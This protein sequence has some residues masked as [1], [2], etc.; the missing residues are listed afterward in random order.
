MKRILSVNLGY[1]VLTLVCVLALIPS[2]SSKRLA[3]NTSTTQHVTQ[4]REFRGVWMPTIY[5]NEY[6][7]LSRQEAREL[8]SRRIALLHRTGCNA[9]IFQIRAEGDAWY[10]SS[11]EPWSRYLSGKQGL[12]PEDGWDP[13]AFA[14]E[15]AHKY[16]MELHAWINPYRGV[17]N[18]NQPL[19]ESHPARRHPE[20]FVRYG[21]QL[22]MDP[23]IPEGRVYICN[24]VRDIVQRY[25][26]DAIHLDDYFYP[27]P[28]AGQPFDDEKSF[29]RYG[30]SAGYRPEEKPVWRRNNINLLIN[31]LSRTLRQIKPWVRLGI[32]P[33]GIYRNKKTDP[34]GSETSGL[35]AYDDLYA[36]VLH[37]ANEGWIDYVAPQ[38]YW[39]IG[40]KAA[41]YEV[42]VRWWRR[43]LKNK[44]VHLYVGQ[45]VKRTMDS[46][47]LSTKL[48]LSQM[49]TS[50]NVLWPA[51]ELLQNYRSI[52]ETLRTVYMS[53]YALI[54]EYRSALGKTKAPD[55]IKELWEDR[56]EDGHM[57][58]WEDLHKP[59]DA[60]TPFFYIV[61][62]FPPKSKVSVKN[63]AAIV[64]I[65][66]TPYYKLPSLNGETPYTFLVTS[67]NRF[68][69]E[70][71][72]YRIEVRI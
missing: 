12:A 36:D 52:S 26:V 48:K 4:K 70:S 71:K 60:E 15:E 29:S 53:G 34:K 21:K 24:I 68:W 45:D 65:S 43:S 9:L 17:A 49:Y 10:R 56:N 5:R 14:L 35:Q 19:A 6:A 32:S 58:V 28:V 69:Q 27:Y 41:D 11:Y 67:I 61:Y 1:A 38:I 62:A 39:N 59:S 66:N 50:G 63:H 46:E 47:Q 55:P 31:D 57:L 44:R 13:L 33:F 42:L 64:S 3:L 40:T 54:P 22:I 8:L 23:G 7:N 30:L 37:W 72:P 20:W 16:G 25:D 18:T 2:C 51:E